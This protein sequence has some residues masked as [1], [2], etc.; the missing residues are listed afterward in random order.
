MQQQVLQWGEW[1]LNR[2][3]TTRVMLALLLVSTLALTFCLMQTKSLEP[4]EIKWSKTYGGSQLDIAHAVVQTSDGGYAL[5]GWTESYGNGDCDVW[6]VKVDSTGTLQWNKTFGGVLA[7]EAF[8]IVESKDGGYALVGRTLSSHTG[9]WDFY[10]IKTDSNG[11]AEW[12]KFYGGTGGDSSFSAVQTSDGGYALAGSTNSFDVSYDFYLI[13]TDSVGNVEWS[14]TYG[15]TND[16]WAYSVVQT[17]DGGYAL[18][19]LTC[20]YGA[21]GDDTWLVKTDSTGNVQWNRT[22]GGESSDYAHSVVETSDGGYA[23]AGRTFSFGTKGFWLVKTDSSGNVQWNQT[24]GGTPNDIAFSMIQSNDDGYALAGVTFGVGGNIRFVKTDAT[25]NMQW[26]KRY[27]GSGVEGAQSIIQTNDGGYALAGYTDS[28]GAGNWDFWLIKVRP[29]SPV[30]ATQ[31]LIENIET[32]NLSKG[33]ETSLIAKLDNA[34]HLLDKGNENGA[35]HK[36]M[37]FINQVKALREKKLT[38]EQTD[39]LIS[40]AQRIIDLINR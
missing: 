22:Y 20:S 32:W 19:G 24:Y 3:A 13:K 9:D 34:I 40:E 8:S 28:Y 31:E 21:G 7:D 11:N 16:E 18:A 15:G 1:G 27:G 6:L 39:Y 5:A 33:I 23:L 30:E 2:K 25:G 36:L 4:P 10:L 26:S 12:S 38:G 14:K 35:V 37:A 17:N 29:P